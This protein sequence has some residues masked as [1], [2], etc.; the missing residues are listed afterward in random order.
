V[1]GIMRFPIQRFGSD[2]A[3]ERRAML[4]SILTLGS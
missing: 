3:P 4:G 1:E 2:S